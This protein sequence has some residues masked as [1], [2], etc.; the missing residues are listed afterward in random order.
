MAGAPAVELPVDD[1]H[2]R[3]IHPLAVAKLVEL[4]L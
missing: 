1:T 2:E 3:I 4:N